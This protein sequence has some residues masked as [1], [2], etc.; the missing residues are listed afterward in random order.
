MFCFGRMAEW[1]NAPVLK[2][3]DLRGSGSSNLSPSAT[4][5]GRNEHYYIGKRNRQIEDSHWEDLDG[6]TFRVDC[7][8]PA[9]RTVLC[10][11]GNGSTKARN[12]NFVCSVAQSLVGIKEPRFKNEIATTNDID[13]V[14][15]GY[16]NNY[17]DDDSTGS[18]TSSELDELIKSIFEPLYLD[19]KGQIRPTNEILQNFNRITFFAHCHGAREVS[20]ITSRTMGRMLDAGISRSAA[21][22]AIKQLFAV[23][24]APIINIDCPNLQVITERDG[25]LPGGPLLSSVSSKFLDERFKNGRIGE[26][27][28]AFQEDDHTISLIA[29]NLTKHGEVE[30]SIGT[31][32]RDDHWKML[33]KDLAYGDEVSQ[34][35]GVVLSY[36]I[37]R[38]SGLDLSFVLQKVQSIL[39]QT[40]NADFAH[41]ID[42]IQGNGREL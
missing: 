32:Q 5:M 21:N 23:A 16:G 22:E 26:G 9:K 2:T 13:F 27:T 17:D 34:A 42:T 15:I 25:M 18:L 28:V 7:S 3:G 41:Q 38:E 11:G 19:E 33:E 6:K 36:A 40:Q 20:E 8:T 30:H 29:S 39:G 35:M 1:S 14:G 4:K 10:F 31:I 37:T 12:A 24:Y